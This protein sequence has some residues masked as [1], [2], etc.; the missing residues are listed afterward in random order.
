ML[1]NAPLYTQLVSTKFYYGYDESTP[2]AIDYSNHAD[3]P[4]EL[5][6]QLEIEFLCA[7]N[8][9]LNVSH[10]EFF[11]KLCTV[12]YELAMRQGCS[13]G[14]MTYTEMALL[15]P[16]LEFAKG[17]FKY[18]AM[19]ALSYTASVFTIAGAFLLASQVP[20]TSLYRS[21]TNCDSSALSSASFPRSDLAINS[22]NET[23][24]P[25]PTSESETEEMIPV[26]AP[27]SIPPFQLPNLDADIPPNSTNLRSDDLIQHIFDRQKYR[28]GAHEFGH[29]KT[30]DWNESAAPSPWHEYPFDMD[31]SCQAAQSY[32]PLLTWLQFMY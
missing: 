15:F 20:G 26:A 27:P 16:R 1:N 12:E 17:L 22:S 14:W 18:S 8:W 13:R 21:G 30:S 3:I 31:G 6:H 10:D 5:M 25:D 7:I 11:A 9:N 23:P 29:T 32:G 4:L 28:F 24:L 19:F 2:D